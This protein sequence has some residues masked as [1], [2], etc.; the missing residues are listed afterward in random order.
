MHILM[1]TFRPSDS[2]FVLSTNPGSGVM[3]FPFIWV[4]Q[5]DAGAVRRS[6]DEKREA[7]SIKRA[8]REMDG[9][10]VKRCDT[11]QG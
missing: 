5:I 6:E 10:A 4:T 2:C 8:C 9:C 7:G 1:K 11:V 3:V